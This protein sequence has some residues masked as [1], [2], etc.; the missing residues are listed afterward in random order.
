[1]VVRKALHFLMLLSFL[2]SIPN[3]LLAQEQTATPDAPAATSDVP[4]VF[5]NESVASFSI[6]S[7]KLFWQNLTP[8][9]CDPDQSPKDFDEFIRRVA[10]QGSTVRT[11][12]E[13]RTTDSFCGPSITS[14]IVADSDNVYFV[15]NG[16]LHR[17][18]VLANVGDDVP[19]LLASL[20]GY[21]EL[22]VRGEFVYILTESAGLWRVN[23]EDSTSI[24]LL[25]AGQVGNAL[26]QPQQAITCISMG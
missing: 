15:R 3:T 23:K 6:A 2:L 17:L 22:L 19:T 25:T 11:L 24:R 26:R 5:V 14:N 9:N 7:P 8:V 10:L 16:L 21:A 18:S 20:N 1:M 13:V 4:D 12:Y